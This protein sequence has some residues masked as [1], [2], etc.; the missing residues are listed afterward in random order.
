M[1][2][3]SFK[4]LKGKQQTLSKFALLMLLLNAISYSS[5]WADWKVPS[6]RE[7]VGTYLTTNFK[8]DGSIDSRS[9]ITFWADGNFSF[10]DSNQGGVTG[11]FNPFTDAAGSW[12]CIRKGIKQNVATM[13]TLDFTLPGTVDAD[14]QI[15]RLDFFDVTVD[16]K[17]GKIKGSAKLQ[18]FPIDSNP[19]NPPTIID[20][21][22]MFEGERVTV[23]PIKN[24]ESQLK[25]P[26]PLWGSFFKKE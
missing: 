23:R 20:D 7:F 14:Q 11:E 25:T 4:K 9:L 1:K 26:S 19:L 10:I 18:F 3:N 22:F 13:V 15:A 17:T 12:T 21:P 8:E 6:C 5:A 24:S 16:R 2:P